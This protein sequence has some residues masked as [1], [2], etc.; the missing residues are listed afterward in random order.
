VPSNNVLPVVVRVMRDRIRIL[1]VAGAPS[2]DVKFLRRF[3]KGDPSVQLVSF[4]ILR[5]TSDL[6]TPYRDDELSLI[7]FPYRRLFDEDLWSFDV[8][9][10]QNF[11]HRDYFH[12]ESSI[13]L[14]NIAQY[15]RDGGAFVMVGGDRSF[16]MGAYGGT[17]LEDVLPVSLSPLPSEPLMTPFQPV[18]TP[19]GA[20]H[21]VT[22]LLSSSEENKEWWSR[23]GS[24]EGINRVQGL[25]PGA[26]LLL[27]HPDAV[28]PQGDPQPVLAVREAGAGRTLSLM[29]DS[30]WR[31]SMAE[32]AQGRGNQAY[33]RF[34]KGALRW[35]MRDDSTAR[36]SIESSKENY[37]LGEEVRMVVRARGADF[38]RLDGVSV[39][40]EMTHRDGHQALHSTTLADGEAVFVVPATTQGA[41][42]VTASVRNGTQQVGSAETVFA[43]TSRDP[44]LEDVAPDTEFLSWLASRHEGSL[45][46]SGVY[47]DVAVDPDAGRT[48]HKREETSLGRIPALMGWVMVFSGL[49][50]WTRRRSGLR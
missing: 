25:Q 31:W 26:T 13:L 20:R 22:R 29:T 2:W 40:V 14:A 10:F 28:T 33:L 32:V 42:R 39:D 6:V 36:V 37:A 5:T 9:I 12:S 24:M 45:N 44:E 41:H 50:W 4:F 21:P 43:V 30:S 38:S 18:L 34:W 35:L 27:A 1:Q 49:G 3:L 8:V 16:S 47:G 19:S 11:D 23:L 46:L 48:V 15:V 7:Q 17:P